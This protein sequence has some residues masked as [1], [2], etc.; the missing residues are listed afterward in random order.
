MTCPLGPPD[1]LQGLLLE[2]TKIQCIKIRLCLCSS[3]LL[4]RHL[5]KSLS[6]TFR[7]SVRLDLGLTTLAFPCKVISASALV[8][9]FVVA[10]L[11]LAWWSTVRVFVSAAPCTP[12]VLLL[13]SWFT[14]IV[15]V[16]LEC[17]GQGLPCSSLALAFGLAAFHKRAKI[18]RLRGHQ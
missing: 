14:A 6:T 7:S 15:A 9:N 5:S 4:I 17:L 8:A 11:L 12:A 18:H 3:G 2:P 16:T 13:V 1:L 10:V